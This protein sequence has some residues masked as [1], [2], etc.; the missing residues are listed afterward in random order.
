MNPAEVLALE[1]QQFEGQGLKTIVPVVY[2]RTAIT[3]GIK[4]SR[5]P[6]RDWESFSTALEG[7]N[8]PQTIQV[9]WMN[10]NADRIDFGSGANDRSMTM[11]VG[12]GFPCRIW[13][14]GR[15]VINFEYLMRGAAFKE[16]TKRVE[17]LTRLN[18]IDDVNLAADVITGRARIRM[19]SL[20]G[21]RRL[22]EFLAVMDWVVSELKK[23]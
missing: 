19:S 8:D 18:Q 15:F 22:N 11:V 10:Q 4:G 20:V 7:G 1:L 6:P 3:R 16:E 23:K 5:R 21:G 13:S 9:A 12:G 2:G 17:L 14:S